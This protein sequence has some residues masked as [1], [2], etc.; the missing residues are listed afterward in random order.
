[1]DLLKM[2]KNMFLSIVNMKLRDEF[3]EIEDLCS[4]YGVKKEEVFEKLKEFN[5]YYEREINQIKN[6]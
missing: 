5:L 1:M 6:I 4:F 2:D 3:G